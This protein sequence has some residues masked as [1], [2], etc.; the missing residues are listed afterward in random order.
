MSVELWFAVTPLAVVFEPL[1]PTLTPGETLAPTL[2]SLLVT[3]TFASTPTFG[4]TFVEP[5]TEPLVAPVEPLVPP[6]L[7]P[8][9][10]P[11][12][13]PV[14]D[15]LVEPVEEP[16]VEPVEFVVEFA[17]PLVEPVAEPLMEP[18][19]EPLVEPMVDPLVVPVA[20]PVD[21][22]MPFAVAAEVESA[23]QSW[24]TGL[25]E[26]SF[27]WPV[28]LSAS[29]PAFGWLSSLQSGVVDDEDAVPLVPMRSPLFLAVSA[30]EVAPWLWVGLD[31]ALLAFAEEVCAN[32]G[33]VPRSAAIASVLRY[34]DRI[35][36]CLLYLSREEKWR[37][38]W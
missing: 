32:A 37:A 38:L 18:V 36:L 17:E 13:V 20:E 29:L 3:F 27:A 6:M 23:M 28:D 26:C 19:A 5:P 12:V 9:V 25:A 7:E 31:S 8:E 10:E 34:V 1:E 4:L 30:R 11:V 14:L 22:P 2:R 16:I 33:A 35:M 24:W 21:E 15:P